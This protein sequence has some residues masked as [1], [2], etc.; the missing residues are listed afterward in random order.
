MRCV[1]VIGLLVG[2][3]ADLH[4]YDPATKIWT[5]LSGSVSGTQPSAR[6]QHGFVAAG[7]RI[8]VFGG[9]LLGILHK[10]NANGLI[11]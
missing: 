9:M 4:V 5:D 8:Y 3:L 11:V 10:L 1:P 6:F 2:P 7:G